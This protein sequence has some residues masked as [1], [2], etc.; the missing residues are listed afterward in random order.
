VI[1]RILLLLIGMVALR[2]SIIIAIWLQL[3]APRRIAIV[4]TEAVEVSV[5]QAAVREVVMQPAEMHAAQV[6]R[7]VT[8][9][10]VVAGAEPGGSTEMR[11][12]DTSGAE[13]ADMADAATEVAHAA[14]AKMAATATAKMAA[15]ATTAMA[16]ATAT[17]TATRE[18][19][20]GERGTAES[21]RG[22]GS[23]HDIS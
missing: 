13:P 3:G 2:P 7:R 14:T 10:E 9:A 15:T 16:A 6:S 18:C 20:R 8:E 22:N 4:V 11:A 5:A 12:A 1:H 21:D 19:G 23:K 17:A